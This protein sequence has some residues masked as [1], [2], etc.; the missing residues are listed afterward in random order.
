MLGGGEGSAEIPPVTDEPGPD[1]IDLVNVSGSE[2]DRSSMEDIM[3][4]DLVAEDKNRE[5]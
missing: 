1:T 5:C 4:V 2:A 3:T